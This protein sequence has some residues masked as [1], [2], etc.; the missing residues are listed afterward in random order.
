MRI[1]STLKFILNHPLN[2]KHKLKALGR[3]IKWQV[4]CFLNPYP[5]IYSFTSNSKLIIKKGMTGATGNLYCGLH[6]FEDMG[7][8]LHFLRPEDT[9]VDIGANIGS[10]TILASAEVGAKSFSFEPIPQTFQNLVNNISINQIGEKVNC[11]NIGLGSEKKVLKFT[12]NLDTVNHITQSNEQ[13]GID[14]QVD[15]LDDIIKD[16][17]PTLIKIDVEGYE[18]EVIKGGLKSI[19]NSQVVIIELNGSGFKYG[20]D[21]KEIFNFF[22]NNGFLPYSYNPINRIIKKIDNFG[23][24]NTIFI[25][26]EKFVKERLI[27]VKKININNLEF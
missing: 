16:I 9:F 24:Q 3:L 11:Y 26:N 17:V 4:N 25:K 15:R 12:N 22:I 18:T 23:S 2:R 13:D 6:E 7:F 19:L 1:L 21:E 10:Y 14:V 8:L 5:I 27:D 20:F